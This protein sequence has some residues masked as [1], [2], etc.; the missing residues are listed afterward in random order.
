MSKD[1]G[2]FCAKVQYLVNKLTCEHENVP[3]KVTNP[4]FLACGKV[5][6]A[7]SIELNTDFADDAP[8]RDATV[9]VRWFDLIG[10]AHEV[11][12][13]VWDIDIVEWEVEKMKKEKDVKS[14]YPDL[15]REQ[16][17]TNIFS[18]YPRH[19]YYYDNN[20]TTVL[21]NDGTRTTVKL[22]DDD[23][24]DEYSAFCAALAKRIYGSNSRIK[25]II[26][27]QGRTPLSK[28]DKKRRKEERKM[29]A[30]MKATQDL[31]NDFAARFRDIFGSEEE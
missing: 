17:R 16:L 29:R 13:S 3:V 22:S 14:A 27:T 23:I 6:Y 18:I 10:G 2:E 4:T 31:I 28:E 15:P 5:S 26:K 30:E 21:W 20:Y 7:L 25:K 24:Y 1:F 19:I 11:A 8:P 12:I 9:I